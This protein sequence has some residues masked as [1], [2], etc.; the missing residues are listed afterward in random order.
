MPIATADQ[1]DP[2]LR[3]AF[4]A[5]EKL[6]PAQA[7]L[8]EPRSEAAQSQYAYLIL[9]KHFARIGAEIEHDETPT[10]W[11]SFS[12]W[13]FCGNV[14][15]LLRDGSHSAMLRELLAE[16]IGFTQAFSGEHFTYNLF[17]LLENMIESQKLRDLLKPLL[18]PQAKM[19]EIMEHYWRDR[20]DARRRADEGYY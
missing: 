13:L 18:P 19:D 1:F 3:A 12:R 11:W 15:R 7:W 14:E 5:P 10:S 6:P 20:D 9:K 17:V 2:S 16:T 8:A 4:D